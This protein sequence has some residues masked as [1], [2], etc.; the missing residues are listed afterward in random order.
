MFDL[1]SLML[2]RLRRLAMVTHLPGS[3]EEVALQAYARSS[4]ICA[5]AQKPAPRCLYTDSGP[6]CKTLLIL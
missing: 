5:C 6:E 2:P 4:A 3:A 1:R